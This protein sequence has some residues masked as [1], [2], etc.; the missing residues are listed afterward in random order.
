M[1]NLYLFEISKLG[2]PSFHTANSRLFSPIFPTI[3]FRNPCLKDA[4]LFIV[5]IFLR[6]E[7]STVSLI[8]ARPSDG[9]VGFNFE[10]RRVRVQVLGLVTTKPTLR[11]LHIGK[12]GHFWPN[13]RKIDLPRV[14]GFNDPAPRLSL[15]QKHLKLGGW[16]TR[17]GVNSTASFLNCSFRSVNKTLTTEG[18][19]ERERDE[20]CFDFMPTQF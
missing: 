10:M 19:R 11:S 15:W 16:R 9:G 12:R 13:S 18:G 6:R 7:N 8:A 2:L 5:L 14:G 20:W 4:F 3:R 1:R 17:N